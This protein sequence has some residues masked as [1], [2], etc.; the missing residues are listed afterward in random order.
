MT[1]AQTQLLKNFNSLCL[2]KNV[3]T[4]KTLCGRITEILRLSG[5]DLTLWDKITKDYLCNNVPFYKIRSALELEFSFL[6]AIDTT[7]P[8]LISGVG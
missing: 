3:E 6:T 1:E 5:N 4:A 2:T 8:V 7:L